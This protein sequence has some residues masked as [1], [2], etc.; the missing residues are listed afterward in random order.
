M[1][2]GM[3]ESERLNLPTEK[4]KFNIGLEIVERDSEHMRDI[5]QCALIKV[6]LT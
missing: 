3:H 6:V 1:C 5:P 2:T 4:N